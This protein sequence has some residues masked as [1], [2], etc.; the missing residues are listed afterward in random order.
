MAPAPNQEP[1]TESE[2]QEKPKR[3][4]G[5]RRAGAGR[6]PDVV[7]RLLKGVRANTIEL[8]VQDFD[9]GSTKSATPG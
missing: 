7:K 9:V 6:K 3:G 8:A 5:G 2:L 4:R 1:E